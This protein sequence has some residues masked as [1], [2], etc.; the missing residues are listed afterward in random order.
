MH[1]EIISQKNYKNCHLN[2]IDK[3][4]QSMLRPLNILQTVCLCPKYCIKNNAIFPNSRLSNIIS[5]C[6]T[7]CVISLFLCRLIIFDL[8]LP[9]LHFVFI[10]LCYD[11][12]FY[13]AGFILNYFLTKTQVHKNIIFVLTI[14]SIHRFF[15]NKR[16]LRTFTLVNWLFILWVFG[17]Y[18]FIFYTFYVTTYMH[19][20]VSLSLFCF[21]INIIYATRCIALLID[22]VDLWNREISRPQ[23]MRDM[24]MKQYCTEIFQTYDAILSAYDTLKSTFKYFVSNCTM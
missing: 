22:L 16:Y 14:Q 23:L 6:G 11:F 15:N 18:M 19:T 13:S 9:Y 5:L 17:M 4:I 1:S 3:D 12:C 8:N 7:I 10:G 2:V 24:D 20:L 21:D